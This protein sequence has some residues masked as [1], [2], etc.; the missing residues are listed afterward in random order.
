MTKIID[1]PEYSCDK[2][3]NIYSHKHNKTIIRKNKIDSKS[4]YEHICLRHNSKTI[5]KSVH[6]IIA[7]TFIPNPENKP[8]IN[9]IDFNRSNNNMSNLEWVTRSENMIHSVERL[10][11]NAKE[12][13]VFKDNIE[14]ARFA[15]ATKALANGYGTSH[16]GISMC[17]SGKTNIHNGYR[18]E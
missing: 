8:E 16:S 1:Y 6:R 12:T 15:S 2:D 18:F 3:G 5:T 10:N 17:K 7:K 4:G 14:I 13:I 11:N 9:H